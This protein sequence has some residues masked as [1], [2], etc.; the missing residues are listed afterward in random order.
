MEEFKVP[1]RGVRGRVLLAGGD[2]FDGTFYV[3]SSGPD[4]GPGQLVDRLN[5]PDL[6]MPWTD[7]VQ[8]DLLSK[9]GIVWVRVG[10]NESAEN[11]GTSGES[12]RAHVAF[13]IS[14]GFHAAG[15][16]RYAMPPERSRVLD[17]FNAAPRF[18]ELRGDSGTLLV[19]RDHIVR[20]R[21][22]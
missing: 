22:V 13:D 8:S 16:L 21:E 19:N 17:Y 7:D 20:I 9:S 4:G 12:C 3:P 2:E 11:H 5:D 15:E 14:G 10:S 1:L 6:Y 18:I